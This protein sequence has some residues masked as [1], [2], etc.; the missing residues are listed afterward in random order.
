MTAARRSMRA[1]KEDHADPA[2]APPS[3]LGPRSRGGVRAGLDAEAADRGGHRGLHAAGPAA[4]GLAHRPRRRP[5]GP[6]RG[7]RRRAPGTPRPAHRETPLTPSRG[8]LVAEERKP[9]RPGPPRQLG[10][11]RRPGRPHRGPRDPPLLPPPA[12]APFS[13]AP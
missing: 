4:R 12:Y 7:R 9:A 6:R 13:T 3:A 5:P 1:D 8:R 11:R 10:L 2:P